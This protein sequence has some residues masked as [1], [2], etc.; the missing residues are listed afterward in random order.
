MDGSPHRYR[1]CENFLWLGRLSQPPDRPMDGAD[2]I[3]KLIGCQRVVGNV[4]ADDLRRVMQVA[5]VGIHRDILKI[6]FTTYGE[7]EPYEQS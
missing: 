6:V 3:R 1:R 7:R 5:F 2:Q 4:L